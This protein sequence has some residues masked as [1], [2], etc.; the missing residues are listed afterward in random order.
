MYIIPAGLAD[1]GAHIFR[2]PGING[3]EAMRHGVGKLQAVGVEG[4]TLYE[5]PAAAVESSLRG[6]SRDNCCGP[7]SDESVR[8]EALLGAGCIQR[9]SPGR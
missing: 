1:E 6:D 9:T 2:Q 5:A 8:Y 7:G 4:L 3:N